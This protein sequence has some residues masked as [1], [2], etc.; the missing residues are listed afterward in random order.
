MRNSREY[1][2]QRGGF[3]PLFILGQLAYNQ[4]DEAVGGIVLALC[5]E[6]A[7][8][9]DDDAGVEVGVFLVVVFSAGD[10]G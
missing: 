8:G 9:D 6:D 4:D 1:G 3:D 2:T 7:D 10:A 5:D